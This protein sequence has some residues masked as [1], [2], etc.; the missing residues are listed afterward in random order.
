MY[1][2]DYINAFAYDAR[3]FFPGGMPGGM[4][5]GPPPGVGGPGFPGGPGGLG[6]QAPST[7]ELAPPP[8]FTP[9][10]PA[11]QAFAVD[12]ASLARCRFRYVY[13]WQNNGEQYWM[14]L[15][16]VGRDSISGFRWFGFGPVGTWFFWGIDT[17]R[18]SQF[19][20]F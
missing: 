19:I 14:Y 9:A 11:V 15:T 13:I 3:G 5:G 8:A 10:Q 16:F 20:C 7:A 2:D 6:G 17:R 18:I 1:D 4:P 12:A